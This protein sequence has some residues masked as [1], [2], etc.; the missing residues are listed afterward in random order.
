MNTPRAQALARQDAGIEAN[1]QKIETAR[2]ASALEIMASR[3]NISPAG[4]QKTLRNTVFAKATDDEF[5]ALVIVANEYNLN[6]LTKEIYAYPKKGGGIEPIVSVDGWIRITNEHPQFDGIEFEYIFDEKGQLDAIEASIFRKDRSR[7]I[8]VPEYMDECRR[9]TDPWKKS[10][11]R[12]L[13]HRALIQ[14][15]RVAFGFS[16]LADENDV[17]VI[18]GGDLTPIRQVLPS[19]DGG[20]EHEPEAEVE[21][22]EQEDIRQDT[23]G[24]LTEVDE[25]TARQL[26][27]DFDPATGEV[28]RTAGSWINE[29]DAV[30]FMGDLQSI[31]RELDQ[32]AVAGKG[33]GRG[34]NEDIECA[35]EM[36]RKEL[37]GKK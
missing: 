5:A 36:K 25:E 23:S 35:I 2:K 6:P 34:D 10:P 22:E 29:I 14:C 26:D 20:G 8:K 30:Q 7:P 3:L 13:R 27:E 16:G 31:E 11:K 15:A 24:G 4:L 28:A 18:Q 12:M 17:D 21:R 1:V 19:G 33:F 37:G 32:L 9:E